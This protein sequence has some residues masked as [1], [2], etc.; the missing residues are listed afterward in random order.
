MRP[1]FVKLVNFMFIFITF[2]C[3]GETAYDWL[4]LN[5]SPTKNQSMQTALLYAVFG[6][7]FSQKYSAPEPQQQDDNS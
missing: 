3:I 7:L 5:I 1:S 2:I 6:Y 4:A